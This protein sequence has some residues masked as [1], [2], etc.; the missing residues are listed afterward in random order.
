MW[1]DVNKN[2]KKG[3]EDIE[4]FRDF[5]DFVNKIVAQVCDFQRYFFV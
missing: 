1:I 2:M 5:E 3:E 4:R